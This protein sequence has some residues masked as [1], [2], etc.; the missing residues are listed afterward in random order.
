VIFAVKHF[1]S[2]L[3]SGE[4]S[5]TLYGMFASGWMDQELF[6]DW[7]LHNF[8][9]HAI[10]SRPLLLLLDGHSSHFTLEFVK[11]AAEHYVILFCVLP[12]TTADTQPFYASCFK[13][14]KN[15]WVDVCCKYLFANLSKVITKFQFSGL[16]ADAWSKGMTLSTV[17]SGFCATGI[18]YFNPKAILDKVTDSSNNVSPKNVILSPLLIKKYERWFESGYNIFTD[19]I[20]EMAQR[21][22]S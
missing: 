10:A 17:T 20:F 13:P 7:F 11:L 1:N 6:A 2:I 22:S 19:R 15:Y 9:V 4:V 5:A 8:L 12:H 21:V 18:Y 16:F 14:L 3:A